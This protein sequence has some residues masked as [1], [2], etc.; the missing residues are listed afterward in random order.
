MPESSKSLHSL[1]PGIH[2]DGAVSAGREPVPDVARAP[3]SPLWVAVD[4]PL[5]ALDALLIGT[6]EYTVVAEPSRRGEVVYQATK[7]ARS[8][9]ITPGLNVNAALAI[10][11][12]LDVR[13]RDIDAEQR[14][15]CKFQRWASCFTPTVSMQPPTTLLFE[16]AASLKLFGGAGTLCKRLH[17]ELDLTGYR[18]FVAVTPTPGASAALAVAGLE[19][20]VMDRA[21]L[22]TSLKALPVH[23]LM[24]AE[25]VIRKLRSVG[26]SFLYELWRLPRHDLAR[27]FGPEVVQKIDRVLGKHPDPR[28]I[29]SMPAR[30]ERYCELEAETVEADFVLRAAR[31]LLEQFAGFLSGRNAVA[32][33][34]LVL[35][36]HA[37]EQATR[38]ELG[39]RLPTCDAGLWAKLLHEHM[40]R[41]ALCAPV[42]GVHLTGRDFQPGSPASGNL[43]EIPDTAKDWA[44]ALDELEA[45][46]GKKCLWVP[47]VA[48]DYR[49]EYAWRR[50]RSID[51]PVVN[52]ARR[53]LWLLHEPR[54]LGYTPDRSPDMGSLKIIN[55][56]E[57]IE[58]GWWNGSDL[59]RDYYMAICPR[60]RRLWIFQDLK[61]RG[62]WYLHGLFG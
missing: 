60:G 26:V 51:K 17:R 27:R 52:P 12:G 8:L 4:F 59:A 43:F 3:A 6:D 1:D 22:R 54:R 56:P 46:L 47:K 31:S 48:A 15:L 20:V 62:D 50:S 11:T 44:R 23:S 2:R 7:K 21:E 33:G 28:A 24:L 39:S 42:V 25:E 61:Q 30:F 18:H 10:C 57:R 38:I 14:H 41:H 49:P 35:L 45:R 5:L 37:E 36:Q 29:S 9:G 13:S 55:G 32:S 58:S 16:I 19:K 34:I 53:P 40:Q